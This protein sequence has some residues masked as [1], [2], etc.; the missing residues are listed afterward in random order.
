MN[1]AVVVAGG[2]GTRMNM[3]ESKQFIKIGGVPVIIRTLRAF[4]NVPEINKI[5][6]VT[7][8]CDITEITEMTD[9]YAVKKVVS[10]IEG[11]DT[12]QESVM[13]GI[14]AAIRCC[15]GINNIQNILIH[16][17]ARPFVSGECIIGVLDA[18]KTC[19]A[20]A[21]GVNIKDTI[22]RIDKDGFIEKTIDR[23]NL[24]SIQTPQGFEAK[25]IYNAHKKAAEC[26]ISATDDCALVESLAN[27]NVKV[28]DGDYNNIK[29]TTPE[30]IPLGESILKKLDSEAEMSNSNNANTFPEFRTGIGYDVHILTD[31]RKLILG[32]IEI[33]HDK[34]LLG[35]SDADVLVHAVMD[36]LLGAAALGDIGKHFP[37]TDPKYKGANSIE[38]LCHVGKLLCDNG[39]KI[40][41]IDSIIV[42]QA[43]KVAPYIESM[44]Q[45]IANALNIDISRVSVKAT[46][47]ENL[48][49]EGRKEGISAQCVTALAQQV[50]MI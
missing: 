43:P 34:G 37:D 4:S 29:I 38:L 32:G 47:T 33:P 3:K 41:N 17:G 10:V 40:I 30:D 45:N 36:A 14:E 22:K 13:H 26:G 49:F 28:T 18:L 39:Y 31:N 1:V 7:R 35:H 27:V 48:G 5:V 24:I 42:A 6:V 9:E 19:S 11:G 44:R 23:D 8:K 50:R 20:A 15:S 2:N 16:D 25:L 12:R 46:T 21:A